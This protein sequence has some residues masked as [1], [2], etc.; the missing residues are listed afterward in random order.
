M[1]M[2]LPED[3]K[4]L[5]FGL[6]RLPK[7]DG[8]IDV[9]ETSRMVDRFLEEGYKYFDTAFVYDGSE[10]AIRKALVE[11]HPRD[12]FYLA[13]KL[14]AWA[15]CK[16]REDAEKQFR[17]SLER[18]GAGYFDFYLLHDL[19]EERTVLYDDL[20][21]W[22]MVR[23]LKAEGLIRHYGFSFH[24]T[25]DDLDKVLAAHP[26]AEFVQ[27]QINYIDW[28]DEKVQSRAVYETARK[29]GK[30]VVIME[31]V[32]GGMLA[33]PP[34]AVVK[35]MKDTQPDMTPASWAVRFAA[36]LPGVLTV[37]SGMSSL[38]QMEDNLATMNGF[39]GLSAE[40]KAVIEKAREEIEKIPTIPCTGCDYCANV[41]PMEIGISGLFAARNRAA[42]FGMSP[43]IARELFFSV[44][45][46][47]KKYASECI[48]CGQCE[49]VCPQHIAIRD[50][51]QKTIEVFGK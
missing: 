40:E 14:A 50:E 11:R 5:G 19:G 24:S 29:Y 43:A 44:E 12:S 10:E 41:C 17:T 8:V 15:G 32:K 42:R 45:K 16:T 20:G 7:K 18:T 51:L 48:Q 47:G 3:I 28:E 4:K 23:E 46:P 27:L 6:M 30:P 9:E 26:D 13:T 33:T 38:E 34:E 1:E 21:L 37:L 2:K 31:P 39:T 35:L 25:A 22:D 36:D 49:G